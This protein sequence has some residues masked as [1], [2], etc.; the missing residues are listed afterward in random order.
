MNT[1]EFIDPLF[2]GSTRPAMVLGIPLKPAMMVG[3]FILLMGVYFHLGIWLLMVPIGLAMRAIVATDDQ[4]FRL[5][6]LRFYCRVVR[7]NGNATFWQASSYAPLQ[8]R[9]R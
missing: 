9:R 7:R 5:L 2:G 1:D 3:G 4:M 6:W 8:S